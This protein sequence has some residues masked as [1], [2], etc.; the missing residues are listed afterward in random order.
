MITETKG[1]ALDKPMRNFM[2]ALIKETEHLRVPMTEAYGDTPFCLEMWI[3]M[4]H[5]INVPMSCSITGD[6]KWHFIQLGDSVYLKDADVLI[7]VYPYHDISLLNML[8]KARCASIAAHQAIALL[9][10]EPIRTLKKLI[11]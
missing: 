11:P 2:D 10:N 8:R 1:E 3:D 9:E 5:H 4:S 6:M 7:E